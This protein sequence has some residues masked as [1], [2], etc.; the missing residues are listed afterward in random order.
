MSNT[1]KI[2]SGVIIIIICLYFYKNPEV[3]ADILTGVT[4]WFTETI[5]KLVNFG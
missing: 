4:R 5:P 2:I 1:T 3:F